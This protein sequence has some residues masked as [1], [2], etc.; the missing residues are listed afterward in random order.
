M[1]LGSREP[2][3]GVLPKDYDLR[4]QVL[5][6]LMRQFNSEQIK[7]ATGVPSVGCQFAA[8]T[9]WP[10]SRRRS[11]PD[12]LTTFELIEGH[13]HALSMSVADSRIPTHQGR[14]R[15]ALGRGEGGIPA[16]PVHHR[17]A[18]FAALV[19]VRACGLVAHELVPGDRVLAIGEAP[20]VFLANLAVQSPPG[21]ELPV[22]FT[23]DS[24]VDGV[25]VVRNGR[26][27]IMNR[28]NVITVSSIVI[29][30][31][32]MMISDSGHGDR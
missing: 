23:L 20:E 30:C 3:V 5:E 9:H 2:L 25:V 19:R 16:G 26:I 6:D 17:R 11:P 15:H 10:T 7:Q 24:I 13:R 8:A 29:A 32:G 27:V 12:G 18:G 4:D 28:P 22:P 21:R 14:Q 1:E 31:S